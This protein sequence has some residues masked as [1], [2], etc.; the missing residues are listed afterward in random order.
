[1]LPNPYG[2]FGDTSGQLLQ[3]QPPSSSSLAVPTIAYKSPTPSPCGLSITTALPNGSYDFTRSPT[4]SFFDADTIE[5]LQWDDLVRNRHFSSLLM[6][7][8]TLRTKLD[9]C[10]NKNTQLYEDKIK[11]MDEKNQLQQQVLQL[12]TGFERLPAIPNHVSSDFSRSPSITSNDLPLQY[13]PPGTIQPAQGVASAEQPAMYPPS[14][15]WT[16]S[17]C[18]ASMIALRAKKVPGADV[19]NSNDDSLSD[20]DS[21]NPRKKDAGAYRGSMEYFVRK[22]DGVLIDP[23]TWHNILECTKGVIW[24]DLWDIVSDPTNNLKKTYFKRNHPAKWQ[25]VI[26]KLE[27]LQPL[28]TYCANHWKCESTL[29]QAMKTLREGEKKR[30]NQP[31]SKRRRASITGSR[32]SSKRRRDGRDGGGSAGSCGQG[33]E[34]ISLSTDSAS[35]LV[36]RD[37]SPHPNMSTLMPPNVGS[38]ISMNFDTANQVTHI[39][40]PTLPLSN[41]VSTVVVPPG[42][43]ITTDGCG[44]DI[45]STTTAL[46]QVPVVGP[47]VQVDDLS[48]ILTDG[49]GDGIS[50]QHDLSLTMTAPVQ[51]PPASP[52]VQ[53][54][55]LSTA[56]TKQHF[57]M[58]PVNNAQE[59]ARAEPLDISFIHVGHSIEALTALFTDDLDFKRHVSALGLLVAL[60]RAPT[61][62]I[63]SPS[64]EASAV[65][66]RID[67]ADPCDPSISEDD[68]NECWGH[69]IF[70]GGG[71]HWRTA[72]HPVAS[73]IESQETM[74]PV[75]VALG[76]DA[77]DSTKKLL[78]TLTIKQLEGWIATH[79]PEHMLSDLRSKKKCDYIQ[80]IIDDSRCPKPTAD[81]IK[82]IKGEHAKVG[83]KKCNGKV[84][85]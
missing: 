42:Q 59:P 85:S 28:L 84:K 19:D 3:L 57:M 8:E 18:K 2:T 75:P 80:A 45:A 12:Q 74:A 35:T 61:S 76:Q 71:L 62:T 82:Q 52:R 47:R 23:S 10:M 81:D 21:S 44:D 27:R 83:G 1:M 56:L 68:L 50:E 11:L 17:E 38:T 32:S 65:L 30:H 31:P 6:K 24:S 36:D 14:I 29:V 39:P 43:D 70:I 7:L 66:S 20:D 78:S 79:H 64:V 26:Q 16:S 13:A 67:A 51:V 34:T 48:V 72:E 63:C 22:P 15:L 69:H 55:D 49:C 4:Q 54:D 58:N 40:E 25:A 46:V 37:P 60:A 9:D 41:G 5:L 73:M 33:C 53:V 77:T